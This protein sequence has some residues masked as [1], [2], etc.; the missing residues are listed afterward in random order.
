VPLF[1]ISVGRLFHSRGP[2]TEK[3]L[4]PIWWRHRWW[5]QPHL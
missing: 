1:R 4:S 5:R 2:A 3:L